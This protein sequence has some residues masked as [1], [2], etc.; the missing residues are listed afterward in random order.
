[1]AIKKATTT[2]DLKAEDKPTADGYTVVVGPSGTETSVPDSILESL[3]DSGY[4]K[5]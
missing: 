3:L 4:T 5:K 2:D 1:M